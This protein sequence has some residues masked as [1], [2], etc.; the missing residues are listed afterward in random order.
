MHSRQLFGC[1]LLAAVTLVGVSGCQKEVPPTKFEAAVQAAADLNPT[2]DG[3]PA[4]L[5]VR[6]YPLRSVG[7][8]ESAD[9]F[10]I[11]E[12]ADVLL[13]ADT[14]APAEELN[15][16]PGQ[17]KQV[18]RQFSDDT[19]FLAIIAAYRDVDNATWR[20]VIPI[21]ANTTNTATIKL[22]KLSVKVEPGPQQ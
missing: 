8:F 7:A 16:L 21:K 3:R 2:S 13:A 18:S 12:Q 11:Y 1:F 17:T 14:T 22:E 19:R 4:P 10:S 5:L 6:L 9:F 20:A 15:M